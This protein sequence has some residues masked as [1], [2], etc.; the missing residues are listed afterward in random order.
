MAIYVTQYGGWWKLN[1]TQ[2]RD[3]CTTGAAG[4]G[5]VLPDSARLSRRPGATIGEYRYDHRASS[6]YSKEPSRNQL[7]EPLDWEPYEF[8]EH[9]T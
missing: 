5:Y 2:W 8:K 6:F 9:L 3:V 1:A 7:Y 4:E